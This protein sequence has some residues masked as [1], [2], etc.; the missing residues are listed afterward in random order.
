ML[1]QAF[2]LRY[3][4]Y[5]LERGFLPSSHYPDG[6]ETDKHD[7]ESA[8][9]GAYGH[10]DDLVGYVRLVQP[11]DGRFPFQHHCTTLPDD[12][13]LPHA[14]EAAEISRLMVRKEYRRG[15]PRDS[16]CRVDAND[17]APARDAQR[18]SESTGILLELYRR[19]YIYSLDNHIRYWYAAMEGPLARSLRRWN[20]A[21]TQISAETDYFGP[22]ALYM[23][24]LRDLESRLTASNPGLLDWL[25]SPQAD[26]DWRVQHLPLVSARRHHGL[27]LHRRRAAQLPG[28]GLLARS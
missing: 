11:Q 4:V 24:D 25:R 23:A 27:N 22:V 20:F 8:H 14:G 26:N 16:L 12:L 19:M 13:S 6:R 9:F 3:Q 7:D 5:C 17:V 10:S 18:A 28:R 1:N 15:G 2:E 21:F